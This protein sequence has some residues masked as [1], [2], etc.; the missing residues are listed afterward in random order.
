MK[1]P[2]SLKGVDFVDKLVYN[3][4]IILKGDIQMVIYVNEDQF[5]AEVLE[6]K[7][8][9]LVDFYA[10]WC[11]PCKM[12]SPVLDQLSAEM[13][14]K[15]KIAKINVDDAQDVAMSYGVQSIPNMILFKDGA[16]AGQYIGAMP[17]ARLKAQLEAVL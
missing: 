3:E 7:V 11:G 4:T 13:E 16:P 14:G 9:V 2:L 5:Q 17:K 1:E 12:M 6:S 15:M 8:P 10:D